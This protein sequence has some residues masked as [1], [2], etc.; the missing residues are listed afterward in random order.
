MYFDHSAVFGA[1]IKYSFSSCDS[2]VS[3]QIHSSIL[4]VHYDCRE[5]LVIIKIIILLIN[6]EKN[7]RS[8]HDCPVTD[9]NAT[10]NANN[11][12]ISKLTQVR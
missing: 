6:F 1:K 7:R 4:I 2:G 3:W 11:M 9:S 10:V 8:L 12:L 5:L